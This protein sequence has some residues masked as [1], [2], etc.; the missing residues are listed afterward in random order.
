MAVLANV[1]F[2]DQQTIRNYIESHPLQKCI[3]A[4]PRCFQEIDVITAAFANR[5]MMH[6]EIG[7]NIRDAFATQNQKAADLKRLVQIRIEERKVEG[8]D[9]TNLIGLLENFSKLEEETYYPVEKVYKLFL[10]DL[11]NNKN[12]YPPDKTNPNLMMYFGLL[13]KES[14]SF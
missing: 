10:K 7:K 13:M 1:S 14:D 3:K 6:K 2:P 8:E 4:L 12:F 11:I 5:V 9:T